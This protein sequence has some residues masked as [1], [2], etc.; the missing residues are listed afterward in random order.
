MTTATQ[1]PQVGNP[2]ID[3]LAAA[4]ACFHARQTR[5]QHPDGK[6][7]GAG[8]WYPS[9]SEEQECCSRIRSPS[10][11]YPYSYMVHCRTADHIAHIYGVS[12]TDIRRAARQARQ[13]IAA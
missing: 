13:S 11:A 8:R 1:I 5:Q 10:R 7:D 9:A 2:Q 12:A 6:F 3:N 4:V